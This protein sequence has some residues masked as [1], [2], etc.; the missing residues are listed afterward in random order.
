MVRRGEA[1]P[2]GTRLPVRPKP[3]E[4]EVFSSWWTRVARGNGLS[5]RKLTGLLFEQ[6]LSFS[7]DIDRNAPDWV[8]DGLSSATDVPAPTIRAMT[9]AAFEGLLRPNTVKCS[10]TCAGYC[11]LEPLTVPCHVTDCN[12]AQHVLRVTQFHTIGFIGGWHS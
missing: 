2:W 3:L 1:A 12:I 10:L 7:R 9:L 4:D 5:L 8:I 6:E 11:R